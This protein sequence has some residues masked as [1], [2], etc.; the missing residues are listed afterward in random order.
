MIKDKSSYTAP[1]MLEQNFE[2]TE[3]TYTD[4]DIQKFDEENQEI[5][6]HY[7]DDYMDE[8]HRLVMLEYHPSPL[9]LILAAFLIFSIDGMDD[10]LALEICSDDFRTVLKAYLME[11]IDLF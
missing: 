10:D 8:K 1:K 2:I 5:I 3:Q 7:Y 9:Q 6:Q 4:Y 11:K